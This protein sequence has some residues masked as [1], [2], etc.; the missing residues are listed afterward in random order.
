MKAPDATKVLLAL[1][2]ALLWVG[3][4]VSYAILDGPPEGTGWTAPVFL[5]L[6]GALVF[7]VTRVSD[8]RWL[9]VGAGIGFLSELSGVA[10]GVPYSA[11]EYTGVL[12]PSFLGVPLVLAAAW[13][14]LLAYVQQRVSMLALPGL[15]RPIAAAAWMTAI[16]LVIDPL[17]A[18]PLGYWSWDS[19]GTYYGIPWVN[20]AG[21]FLTSLLIFLAVPRKFSPHLAARWIGGSVIVFFG[22]IAFALGYLLPGLAAVALVG[23]DIAVQAA[24]RHPLRRLRGLEPA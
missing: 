4:V 19:G 11:Y 17:A 9:A 13:L 3:G 12:A 16:D 1:A 22:L 7:S 6:A 20:F 15:W 21:W 8:W 24:R 18:G 23:L 10:F 5:A 2:Y 14:V